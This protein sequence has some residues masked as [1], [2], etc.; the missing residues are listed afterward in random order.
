MPTRSRMRLWS[1]AARDKFATAG[2]SSSR[3]AMPSGG[4]NGRCA[5]IMLG[6]A[7]CSTICSMS[8]CRLFLDLAKIVLC[9]EIVNEIDGGF[10]QADLDADPGDHARQMSDR[11]G[12]NL[13]VALLWKFAA[14]SK[15][16]LAIWNAAHARCRTRALTATPHRKRSGAGRPTAA[17]PTSC[18]LTA[19]TAISSIARELHKKIIPPPDPLCNSRSA[20]M[21]EPP[22]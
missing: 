21:H 6:D 7:N 15:T 18:A 20:P 8:I 12:W 14:G 10:V 13:T 19:T 5:L 1:A 4:S 17:G 9:N 2:A 11:A 22:K 16:R 3:R